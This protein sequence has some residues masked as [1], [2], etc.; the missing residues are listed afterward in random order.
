MSRLEPDTPRRTYLADRL[1]PRVAGELEPPATPPRKKVPD[2]GIVGEALQR[3]RTT[4]VPAP[5]RVREPG[6]PGH[7]EGV[8]LYGSRLTERAAIRV[9]RLRTGEAAAAMLQGF[10]LSFASVT[11]YNLSTKRLIVCSGEATATLEAALG[12]VPQ[13]GWSTVQLG[14]VRAVAIA[15]IDGA[16]VDGEVV[17]VA[18]DRQLDPDS[19][20]L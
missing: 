12:F 16:A 19:G 5:P 13:A 6:L 18:T 2:V 1:F 4:R 10:G 3:R 8:Q 15:T 7:D 11:V 9:H 20:P 14:G 17:I